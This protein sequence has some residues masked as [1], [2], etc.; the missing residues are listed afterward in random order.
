MARH[1]FNLS[2]HTLT[3]TLIP[4]VHAFSPTP[5]EEYKKES[6]PLSD[7]QS[8][9]EIPGGSKLELAAQAGTKERKERAGPDEKKNRRTRE[10]RHQD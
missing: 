5:R 8:H 6:R 4:L 7:M 2:S 1:T 9:S 3:H 10:P